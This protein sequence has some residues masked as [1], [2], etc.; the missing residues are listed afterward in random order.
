MENENDKKPDIK[1]MQKQLKTMMLEMTDLEDQIVDHRIRLE[2]L[3][4]MSDDLT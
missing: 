4:N 1:E 2:D 3:D